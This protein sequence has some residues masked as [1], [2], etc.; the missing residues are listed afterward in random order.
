MCKPLGNRKT[1]RF[2]IESIF[3]VPLLISFSVR[4]DCDRFN[5]I[6]DEPEAVIY[7]LGDVAAVDLAL[8]STV[9]GVFCVFHS[10]DF[11][12][13]FDPVAEMFF[14]FAADS[15]F[16][17]RLSRDVVGVEHGAAGVFGVEVAAVGVAVHVLGVSDG[18]HFFVPSLLVYFNYTTHK[19]L[20]KGGVKKMSPQ[21]PGET[22]SINL[23]T[24]PCCSKSNPNRASARPQPQW[25]QRNQRN[26]H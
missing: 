19:V 26:H 9:S 12:Y 23:Y 25:T 10:H 5:S 7:I 24:Q 13:V 21:K 15:F 14:R 8:D 17:C 6:F 22:S 3:S 4:G 2:R 16:Q 20:L 1:N 18:D 11:F